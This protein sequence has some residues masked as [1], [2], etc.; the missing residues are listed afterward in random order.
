MGRPTVVVVCLMVAVERPAEAAGEHPTGVAVPVRRLE[1]VE[2]GARG[3]KRLVL[4]CR[5]PKCRGRPLVK[6][7]PSVDPAEWASSRDSPE[8]VDPPSPVAI[9]RG[10]VAEGPTAVDKACRTWA[11]PIVRTWET[12]LELP[13]AQGREAEGCKIQ[14]LPIDRE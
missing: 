4:R 8:A 9:D 2:E 7:V 12:A 14:V 10:W 6:P 11:A 3:H 1:A 5:A 13:T